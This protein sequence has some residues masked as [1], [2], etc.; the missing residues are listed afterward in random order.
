MLMDRRRVLKNSTNDEDKVE[1]KSIEDKVAE[2]NLEKV[3]I[4]MS[5]IES[6]GK[7]QPNKIWKIKKKFCPKLRDQAIVKKDSKGNF[8]TT[9]A[10]IKQLYEST[11]K[12]RLKHN[13]IRQELKDLEANKI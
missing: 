5:E 9:G 6:N 1:L 11:Y 2:L 13:L 12:D 8:I 7:V 3:K 10:G 4:E